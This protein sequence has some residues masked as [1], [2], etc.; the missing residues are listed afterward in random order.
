MS[1]MTHQIPRENTVN[2]I[3]HVQN[4]QHDL[5]KE[6]QLMKDIIKNMKE[7]TNKRKPYSFKELCPCTYDPSMSIAPFPPGFEMPKFM[8]YKG[9]DDPRD[10]IHEFHILCQEVSYSDLYICRLFPKSLTG[11]ALVW[12]SS[13]LTT[14]LNGSIIRP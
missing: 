1:S 2:Y 10:H 8:K 11:D 13:L 3:P 5:I 4:P 12:F 9:K 14:L 7:G 6:I